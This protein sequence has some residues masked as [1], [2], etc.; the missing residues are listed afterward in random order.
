VWGSGQGIGAV[1][2]RMGAGEYIAQLRREYEAARAKLSLSSK[3]FAP[4]S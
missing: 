4:I 2:T 1:K 3:E